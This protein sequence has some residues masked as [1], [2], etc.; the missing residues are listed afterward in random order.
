[1]QHCGQKQKEQ[2]IMNMIGPPYLNV[3]HHKAV[4]TIFL[5]IFQKYYQPPVLGILNMSGSFHQKG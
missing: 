4:A 3:L 5:N 1:M 2:V